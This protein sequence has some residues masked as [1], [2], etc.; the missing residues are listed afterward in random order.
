M[1]DELDAL[2]L[3][4]FAES[5]RPLAGA[6]FV[7]RVTAGMHRRGSLRGVL[8]ALSAAA[9]IVLQ[10][11]ATGIAAPL[12]LRYAGVMALAGVLLTAWSLL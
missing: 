12:R 7:A 3:R 11:L 4:T 5:Q 6:E 8:T 9:G 2:L 10:G 1:S